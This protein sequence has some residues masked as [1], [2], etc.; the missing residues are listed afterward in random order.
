MFYLAKIHQMSVPLFPN[1]TCARGVMIIVTGN[2]HTD[3][4]SNPGRG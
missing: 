1:V 2:G 3:I 4:S